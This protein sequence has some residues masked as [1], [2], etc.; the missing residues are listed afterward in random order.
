VTL[1]QQDTKASVQG[2][3]TNVNE[4]LKA[5]ANAIGEQYF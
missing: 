2:I 3:S 4:A 5:Y 1:A